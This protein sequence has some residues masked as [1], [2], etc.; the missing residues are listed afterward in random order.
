MA[1]PAR[2]V[3]EVLCGAARR[4]AVR[5]SASVF[6][7]SNIALVKYWGKRP[8][9]LNLPL[10]SSLSY[11]LGDYG[12]TTRVSLAEGDAAQLNGR[13]A[14]AAEA[15]KIFAFL[16]LFRAEG[17]C[18]NVVTDNNIPTAAGVA[19]S[20]SGFAALTAA[21]VALKGWDVPLQRQTM[22]ARL[23]SGSASRSF[24]PGTVLWHKGI[25]DDGLDCYA[26]PVTLPVQDIR[27]AVLLLE[28][29]QKEIS[30]R[31]AMDISLATSPL[32]GEWPVRQQAHLDA[33]LA[34]PDM[35][36]LGEVIEENAVLMHRLIESA[37]PSIS[38]DTPQTALW[39][40]RI[41]D[42]RRYGLPVWFTQDA[43]PNLKLIF[44]ARDQSG[45]ASRLAAAGVDFFVV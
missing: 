26:D 21:I 8:G 29:G 24:W 10:V 1:D 33:V 23:G 18:F 28:S 11:T 27:M 14:G 34:A 19:S 12:T 22:L 38:F 13:P 32:S 45:I 30:S 5:Q 39:K 25:R 37:T 40:Q 42:W 35:T 3:D 43:G 4:A 6:M 17:E 2:Y 16:D 15:A 31:R 9:P 20:A 36:T 44:D 7:P 41:R